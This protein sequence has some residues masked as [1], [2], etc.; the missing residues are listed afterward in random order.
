MAWEKTKAVVEAVIL[1]DKLT[2][3]LGFSGIVAMLFGLWAQMSELPAVFVFLAMFGAFT[4]ALL[5]FNGW[6]AYLRNR[7]PVANFAAWGKLDVL[8]VWDAAHLW[9]GIEPPDSTVGV[10][11]A[12]AYP[13]FRRLK[14]DIAQQKLKIAGREGSSGAGFLLSRAALKAY[15]EADKEAPE[16]LESRYDRR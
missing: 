8:R 9:A 5:F 4:I 13:I 16:F 10:P 15:A 2:V 3:A 11:H 6:R 14:T 12:K 1:L 7:Y